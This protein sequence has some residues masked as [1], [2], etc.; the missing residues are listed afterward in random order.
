MSMSPLI[1]PLI[2]SR[3]LPMRAIFTL[4]GK[5]VKKIQAR[6]GS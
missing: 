6:K 3:G 4:P 5:P 1:A 2:A